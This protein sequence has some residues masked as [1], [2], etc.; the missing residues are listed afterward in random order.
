MKKH[1]ARHHQKLDG[2]PIRGHTAHGNQRAAKKNGKDGC[3]RGDD[4]IGK[5]RH[6]AQTIELRRRHCRI[7]SGQQ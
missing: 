2:Q 3:R 5:A 4:G 1:H 7:V 6:H